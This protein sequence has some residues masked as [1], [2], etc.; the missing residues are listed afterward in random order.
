LPE[1]L[2]HLHLAWK[3]ATQTNMGV[4]FMK[5]LF[6]A[7]F[8]ALFLAFSANAAPLQTLT[9]HQPQTADQGLQDVI[10]V[11]G[12]REP[13]SI[14]AQDALYGGIAGL[15]IG[16]GVALL[17]NDGNWGRDL[18]VGAGAGLI[19]GGIFGAVD[20]ASMSDRAR[21]V[22]GFRDIGF[23]SGVTPLHGKF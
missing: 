20:A 12:R 8:A 3:A 15:A 2:L 9:L 10:E 19:I 5:K 23:S 6:L 21:P 11:H 17:S 4:F 7:P 13:I 16:G 14:I 1:G 22:D 18:A